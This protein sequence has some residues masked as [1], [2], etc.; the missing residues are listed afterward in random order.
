MNVFLDNNPVIFRPCRIDDGEF[1]N[2]FTDSFHDKWYKTHAIAFTAFEIFFVLL[3]P[4]RDVGHI[5]LNNCRGM[6][7]C[8]LAP[9]HV[10]SDGQTHTTGYDY[11]FVKSSG[12]GW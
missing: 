4:F 12:Y 5:D 2:A 8:A 10:L 1:A 3:Q 11:F 9:H 7:R 6:W